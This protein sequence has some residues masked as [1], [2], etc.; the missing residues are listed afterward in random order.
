[1][2]A[3]RFLIGAGTWLAVVTAA[4][5]G[6]PLALRDRLPDPIA[7][8]WGFSGQPDDSMPAAG[9]FAMVLVMWAL[10]VAGVGGYLRGGGLRDR[11]RRGS[12]AALLAAGTGF[13]GGLTALTLWAN[14]DL[15]HWQQARPL[16]WQA[17]LMIVVSAGL[18]WLGWR[19]GVAGLEPDS[20]PEPAAAELP[21]RGD[22]RAVWVSAVTSRT[23]RAVA[24]VAVLV[25]V[26]LAV[27]VG[28][29]AGLAALLAGLAC[30][31][32]S[33]ARVQVDERGVLVVFGP[34]RWP[35]R[36][37]RLDRIVDARA[38]RRRALEAGGWGYRVLPHFTAIML[39]GGDCL[40]LR[41]SGG[42]DFVISV[43]HPRRGAEYLNALIT[44]RSATE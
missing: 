43:D 33:S 20:A 34:Q 28:W 10:C 30:F 9:L 4:L 38:E 18:G 5:V 40:V 7:S 24:A 15:A 8:H 37:I 1:M 41:L 12:A 39:R 25:G 42:R 26:G 19:V 32:L 35:S 17:L 23:L 22:R 13:V 14:L 36:R 16:N 44:E 31:A 2:N 6:V 29:P 11:Q 3:R 27:V 21:L